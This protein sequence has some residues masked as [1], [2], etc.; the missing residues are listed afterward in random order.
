MATGSA[1]EIEEERRLLYVAMTR[2]KDR[3][4][5]LVPQ[6]FYV[7]RQARRGDRH[8][9]AAQTRFIPAQLH[10]YFEVG[11]WTRFSDKPHA[12]GPRTTAVLDLRARVREMWRGA[13]T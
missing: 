7:L 9:Y 5:L 4:M 2:A 8:L 6:R 1:D 12:G 3:L 10:Q 11:A 13:G